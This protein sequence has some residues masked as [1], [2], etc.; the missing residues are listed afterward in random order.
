MI[1]VGMD[2]VNSSSFVWKRHRISSHLIP[3]VLSR[4]GSLQS[5]GGDGDDPD[6]DVDDLTSSSLSAKRNVDDD[7]LSD[8]LLSVQELNSLC[9]ETN[10][11]P[12]LIALDASHFCH[13]IRM[14]KSNPG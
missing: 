6:V 4:Y 7:D 9:E 3:T 8:L 1:L 12:D 13:L 14:K 11:S 5:S 10:V 2:H